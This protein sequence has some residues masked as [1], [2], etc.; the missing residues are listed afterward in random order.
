MRVRVRVKDEGKGEGRAV[1]RGHDESRCPL[2][3]V[4]AASSS[5][6]LGVLS[7][8]LASASAWVSNSLRNKKRTR[9]FCGYHVPR[10]NIPPGTQVCSIRQFQ[11]TRL[12]PTGEGRADPIARQKQIRRVPDWQY[13]GVTQ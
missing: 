9:Y 1:H 13:H 11:S 5:V 8:L 4:L 10:I 3:A 12:K 6:A 2:R 7:A